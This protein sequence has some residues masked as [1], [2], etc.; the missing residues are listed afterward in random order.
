MRGGGKNADTKIQSSSL[1]HYRHNSFTMSIFRHDENLSALDFDRMALDAHSLV[2]PIRPSPPNTSCAPMI[3]V[4]ICA[5]DR[6][7]CVACW[8]ISSRLPP[9]D[10]LE[11]D[12]TTALSTSRRALSVSSLLNLLSR[13]LVAVHG[14]RKHERRQYKWP[15]RLVDN[16][17]R[18]A[19]EQALQHGRIFIIDDRHK[20]WT[21]VG[22]GGRGSQRLRCFH[23]VKDGI[24]VARHLRGR[25]PHAANVAPDALQLVDQRIPARGWTTQSS[26]ALRSSIRRRIPGFCTSVSS[27]IQRHQAA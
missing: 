15:Y 23:V 9:S 21:V 22:S 8:R 10:L 13:R 27:P 26:G 11:R 25:G 19:V 14:A 20:R 7:F 6:R 12:Q 2:S 24:D 4:A 5:I 1:L 18:I 17:V 3:V 16:A